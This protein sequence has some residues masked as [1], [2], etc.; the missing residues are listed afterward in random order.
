MTFQGTHQSHIMSVLI[1]GQALWAATI[2][3][4]FKRTD[5][6]ELSL[7]WSTTCQ[8]KVK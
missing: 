3:T 7:A 8:H 5:S 2:L 1:H 6:A 4:G